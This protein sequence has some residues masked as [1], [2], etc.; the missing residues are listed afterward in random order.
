M[1]HLWD[2]SPLAWTGF[3]LGPSAEQID[4]SWMKSYA[5][6][7]GQGWGIAPIYV[8]R[9]DLGA[10]GSGEQD[11]G[12]ALALAATAGLP[13][14]GTLY[15]DHDGMTADAASLNYVE[16][17]LAAV[18]AAG[19]RAGLRARPGIAARF[20]GRDPALALWVVGGGGP[21]AGSSSSGETTAADFRPQPTP[22]ASG[23]AAAVLW[24]HTAREDS[25]PLTGGGTP[26]LPAF[27]IAA[28]WSSAVMAN[29]LAASAFTAF[30]DAGGAGGGSGAGA[31]TA[32]SASPFPFTALPIAV[33]P[34]GPKGQATLGI[35]DALAA[36][37]TAKK[38]DPKIKIAVFDMTDGGLDYGKLD[39]LAMVFT[40]SLNKITALGAAF[41]LR[42]ALRAAVQGVSAATAKDLLAAVEAAWGATVRKRFDK[43]PADFPKLGRIFD[44]TP[45]STPGSWNVG[46]QSDGKSPSE[47]AALHDQPAV[48]SLLFFERMLLMAQF[49]DT[50]GAGLTIRDLGF[51]YIM[52]TMAALGLYDA[53]ANKG[54]WLAKDYVGGQWGTVPSFGGQLAHARSVATFFAALGKGVFVGSGPS[55]EM[56]SRLDQHGTRSFVEEGLGMATPP[57][58]YSVHAM[59]IGLYELDDLPATSGSAD[60]GGY[61]ERTAGGKTLK[62]ALAILNGTRETVRSAARVVDE[63]ILQRN[64]P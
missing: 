37:R 33:N 26:D 59:K 35:S 29:P 53:T 7:A 42:E 58:A 25:P 63:I 6:L 18:A 23:V 43:R 30:A 45:G 4:D 62:Y 36:A 34:G 8:G 47:L 1:Q 48:N 38:I 10:G 21:D 22:G 9:R 51:Q 32:I 28:D 19:Y 2:N 5:T 46:F 20:A 41:A 16:S 14:G 15:L 40:A 61:Y 55:T 12:E 52:G 44:V 64:T 57:L 56:V 31:G 13:A 17:W 3:R 27:S 54:L 49:S 39:D 24:R 11:A 60:E 50:T